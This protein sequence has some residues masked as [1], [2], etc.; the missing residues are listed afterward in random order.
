M[1]DDDGYEA[2]TGAELVRAFLPRPQCGN[3]FLSARAVTELQFTFYP[4]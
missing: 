4:A 3:I 1:T 2:T